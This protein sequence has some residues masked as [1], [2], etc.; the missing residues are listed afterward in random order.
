MNTLISLKIDEED[1][2]EL[3]R[4]V[5]EESRSRSNLIRLA[6]KEY[7]RENANSN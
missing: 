5:E 4:L 1:L 2:I 6:I 3:N 7:L